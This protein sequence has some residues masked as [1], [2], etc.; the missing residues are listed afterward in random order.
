MESKNKITRFFLTATF[1]AGLLASPTA[2]QNT[3]AKTESAKITSQYRNVDLPQS[4]IIQAFS[5]IKKLISARSGFL[6][7]HIVEVEQHYR[8]SEETDESFIYLQFGLQETEAS[9][10]RN[11][12]Y[13]TITPKSGKGVQIL[14]KY[15]KI[16]NGF[17]IITRELADHIP[18]RNIRTT[19][20]QFDNAVLAQSPVIGFSTYF[21]MINAD[22]ADIETVYFASI[23]SI[24][25]PNS[26]K[27]EIEPTELSKNLSEIFPAFMAAMQQ[28]K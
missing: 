20:V 12:I 5:R 8:F 18:N 2:A 4:E 23:Q 19:I 27:Y 15:D 11:E 26:Q 3:K 17:V 13:I 21:Q 24:V 25:N 6:A 9:V 7:K 1:L 10:S 16:V 22:F 14:C 28:G